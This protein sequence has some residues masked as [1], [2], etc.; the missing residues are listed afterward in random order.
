[1]VCGRLSA[2]RCR[3]LAW[4]RLLPD[5]CLPLSSQ[6]CGSVMPNFRG[7]LLSQLRVTVLVSCIHCSNT[8]GSLKAR[9]KLCSSTCFA[10]TL[11]IPGSRLFYAPI[12][13][14]VT[15]D[16]ME[17]AWTISKSGFTQN[18]SPVQKTEQ[19]CVLSLQGLPMLTAGWCLGTWISGR[20]PA[21]PDERGSLRLNC[22]YSVVS[23]EHPYFL[24]GV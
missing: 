23:A 3:A 11:L 22:L 9:L 4:T 18:V 24:L 5:L 12:Q 19:A 13:P 7:L 8:S 10:V 20:F 14:Q 1:M 16:L 15:Q 2:P 21:F 6:L 17:D